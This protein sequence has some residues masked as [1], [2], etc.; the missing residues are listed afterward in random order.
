MQS[1]E[2]QKSTYYEINIANNRHFAFVY[3]LGKLD[4]SLYGQRNENHLY[5]CKAISLMSN[6]CI[7]IKI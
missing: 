2:Q 5:M 6:S 7:Y 1:L 4:Y 3:L